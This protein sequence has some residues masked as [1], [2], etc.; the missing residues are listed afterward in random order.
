MGCDMLPKPLQPFI[1][2]RNSPMLQCAINSKKTPK[3]IRKFLNRNASRVDGLRCVPRQQFRPSRTTNRF[4]ITGLVPTNAILRSSLL[5]KS[6]KTASKAFAAVIRNP[7]S[8]LAGLMAPGLEILAETKKP[9]HNLSACTK[10]LSFLMLEMVWLKRHNRNY[11]D[12]HIYGRHV[13]YL[14][15]RSDDFLR[16]MALTH[17]KLDGPPETLLGRLDEE[18][19]VPPYSGD[20]TLMYLRGVVLLRCAFH[21][22]EQHGVLSGASRELLD[23]ARVQFELAHEG[24]VIFCLEEYLTMLDNISSDNIHCEVKLEAMKM[25]DNAFSPGVLYSNSDSETAPWWDKTLNDDSSSED[26]GNEVAEEAEAEDAVVEDAVAEDAVAE[27]AQVASAGSDAAVPW[28]ET[29]NSDTESGDDVI[30][31]DEDSEPEV[32]AESDDDSALANSDSNIPI[33]KEATRDDEYDFDMSSDSD[34][35]PPVIPIKKEATRDDEYDFDMSSDSDNTPPPVKIESDDDSAV[36]NS[37]SNIP[38]KLEATPD[39]GYDFDMSDSD[40]TPPPVKAEP[41]DDY[42][43]DFRSDSEEIKVKTE[44]VEVELGDPSSSPVPQVKKEGFST[45]DD[46]LDSM[47][48][49]KKPKGEKAKK[50]KKSKIKTDLD[51]DMEFDF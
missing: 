30:E 5:H 21:N 14:I 15:S 45:L 51:D 8:Q 32:K 9:P 13:D 50:K 40:K 11:N 16:N 12:I 7:G 20:F 34:N 46:L 31:V 33:K 1:M 36:V 22:I 3:H 10:F 6:W 29:L 47:P 44:P 25:E 39:D 19:M 27:D 26:A 2:K 35:P 38:I 37:D 48:K 43:F 4:T 42:D 23:R 41:T 28:W 18:M 24:G 49:E 17:L